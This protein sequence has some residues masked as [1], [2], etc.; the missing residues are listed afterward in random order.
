MKV[1]VLASD[2]QWEELIEINKV[3]V[4]IRANAEEYFSGVPD[5]DVIIDLREEVFIK[6]YADIK[7]PVL[8]NSV[9]KTLIDIDAGPNIYRINGWPGFLNKPV[10]EI[11]GSNMAAINE[12]SGLLEREFVV[13]GDQPG[14]ISAKII[15][16]IINEAYMTLNEEISTKQEIDIAMKLGTNYPYGPFEWADRIGIQHINSLLERLYVSDKCYQ[17]SPLLVN[18][19]KGSFS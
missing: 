1:I 2:I 17:P 10:W 19:V 13:V 15:S 6:D 9:V 12:L 14:F 18:E 4:F 7:E 8:I 3:P 11:A 5:A 16:M